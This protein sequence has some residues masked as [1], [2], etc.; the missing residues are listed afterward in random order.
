MVIV[1]SGPAK[2]QLQEIIDQLKGIHDELTGIRIGT[3]RIATALEDRGPA[4]EITSI[5]WHTDVPVEET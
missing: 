2:K 3:E 4:P 1:F 5:E